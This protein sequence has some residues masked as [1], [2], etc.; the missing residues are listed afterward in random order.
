MEPIREIIQANRK[1]TPTLSVCYNNI[2][3]SSKKAWL[4]KWKGRS[5]VERVFAPMQWGYTLQNAERAYMADCPTL[6]QYDAL[7]GEG[8]SAY[9]IELQVSGLFGTSTSKD[10]G[11]ADGIRIFSQAFA[12]EVR[13]YKLSELMLFFARYKAGRYDNSY[14]SFDTKR[15]GNAF[16]KEFLPQRNAEIDIAVRHQQQQESMKRREL[17]EGYTIPEGYNPYTWYLE[18]KRRGEIGQPL[19]DTDR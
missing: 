4:S 17:T 2:S 16:F 13:Q 9:W 19:T 15:I 1:L 18:R 8:S 3:E 5:D 14:S 10:N 12:Q 6:M 11:L 7:Y